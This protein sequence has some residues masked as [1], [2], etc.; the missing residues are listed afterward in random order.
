MSSQVSQLLAAAPTSVSSPDATGKLPLHW[1]AMKESDSAVVARL[2]EAHPAAVRATD[3]RGHVPLHFVARCVV[4]CLRL[5]ARPPGRA[6]PHHR[7]TG[8]GM[9][10]ARSMP[11]RLPPAPPVL[12][13]RSVAAACRCA[14]G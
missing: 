5:P 12:L 13:L 9:A 11:A 1:A 3:K 6:P 7:S 14:F 10:T 4:R 8:T 2:L